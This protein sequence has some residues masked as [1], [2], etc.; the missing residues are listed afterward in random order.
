MRKRKGPAQAGS[1]VLL[2]VGRRR[3][4]SQSPDVDG[5]VD[6]GCAVAV[7]GAGTQDQ[8]EVLEPEMQRGLRV[9]LP[10]RV[11]ATVLRRR[12]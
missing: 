11:R 7:A 4:R 1:Y 12:F 2:G 8:R 6:A 5:V 3:L 10:G 9:L